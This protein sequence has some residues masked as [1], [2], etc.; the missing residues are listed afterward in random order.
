MDA[1]SFSPDSASRKDPENE[2]RLSA[3]IKGVYALGYF[4]QTVLQ[5]AFFFFVM[6]FYTD[7]VRLPSQ[8]I[9]VALA[10]GRIFDAVTNPLMGQMSDRTRTRFGRR[11]PY[12]MGGGIFWGVVFVLLWMALPGWSQGAKFAYLVLM[13]I[14]FAV[15]V[16]VF[17]VPYLALGAELSLDY[18][19]RSSIA[20]Y[21]IAFM[22]MGQIV[23]AGMLALAYFIKGRMGQW[24]DLGRLLAWLP[25]TEWSAAAIILGV[26]SIV[27]MF[28][29]GLIPQERFAT[30]AATEFTSWQAF[31]ATLSNANFRR[32]V[33]T[34]VTFYGFTFLGNFMLPYLLI[35]YIKKPA[36]IMPL[37]AVGALS[38][39]ATLPLWV[40]L[41]RVLEKSVILRIVCVWQA[42]V[43][44]L[45]LVMFHPSH[46]WLMVPFAILAGSGQAAFETY[47]HSLLGDVTDEDDL[48]TGQRRE[49]MYFGVYNL[50][51]KL[52]ISVGLVWSGFALAFLGYV[53]NG[54]QSVGTL[55]GMRLLFALPFLP[56]LLGLLYLRRYSL[57]RARLKAIHQELARRIAPKEAVSYE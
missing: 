14:L 55:W 34:Y 52:A 44:P 29:S 25:N 30:R 26:V 35:Y 49:G 21:R 1:L 28:L 57:D 4:G 40:R 56:V 42:T 45:S 10:I 38:G 36:Y 23:G 3:W 43:Y 46:P 24:P 22:Q 9:G 32:V 7:V 27:C 48:R 15:G 2:A 37:Y 6:L 53:P 11:R 39:V 33:A 13:D 17:I 54:E 16:T 8:F 19:E 5:N 12:I 31:R 51:L 50:L 47:S 20:G 18:D 41:G